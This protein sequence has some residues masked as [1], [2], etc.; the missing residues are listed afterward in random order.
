M[1]CPGALSS[2][3]ACCLRLPGLIGGRGLFM[4]TR[5]NGRG[6]GESESLQRLSP[7]P[8]LKQSKHTICD[9]FTLYSKTGRG[10][11]PTHPSP[12]TGEPH[13]TQGE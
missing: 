4:T 1:T 11:P 7:P 9:A 12:C 8:A 5:T 13:G 3:P 6:H 10:H 2:A